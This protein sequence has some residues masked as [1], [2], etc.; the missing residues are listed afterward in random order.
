MSLIS[1]TFLA[2]ATYFHLC[3]WFY[4]VLKFMFS[5]ATQQFLFLHF[6]ELHMSLNFCAKLTLQGME[7]CQSMST[8]LSISYLALGRTNVR[9]RMILKLRDVYRLIHSTCY[10]WLGSGFLI[11]SNILISTCLF[12]L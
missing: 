11:T 7:K 3:N 5:L 4:N 9:R 2:S 6:P 10:P 8:Y 12:C 1:I